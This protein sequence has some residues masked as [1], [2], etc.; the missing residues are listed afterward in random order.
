[1][2]GTSIQKRLG[3]AVFQAFPRLASWWA[4]RLPSVSGPI[5]WAEPR[6]PLREAT[7]ALITTGGVHLR[8]QKPF[9]M[10]DPDGDPT[11]REIPVDTPAHELTITHDYYDHADA[12]RDLALVYPVEPLRT[13]VER[14]ALGRVHPY[15]Y[16]FMG[17]IDGPHV[18]TLVRIQAP[19]VARR[20]ARAEVDY[21]LLVPA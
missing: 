19:E 6:R 20:L 12:E 7:V 9:D 16:G 4:R 17:H 18:E 8:T 10:D 21:A 13:L 14:R 15:A 3:A 11:W 2:G 1:M 5:P